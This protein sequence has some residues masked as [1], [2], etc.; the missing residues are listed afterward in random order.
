MAILEVPGVFQT[1]AAALAAAQP[2]DTINLGVGYGPESVAVIVSNITISGPASAI[3]INLNIAP[4]VI[5]VTLTGDAPINV[6]DSAGGDNV[7]TGNAG[8]NE[9][10]V[11]GGADTVDGGAGVDR[12]VVDYSAGAG[13]NIVTATSFSGNGNTINYSNFEHYTVLTGIAADTITLAGGDNYIDAGEGGNIITSGS[14]ANTVITGSAPDTITL[15]DG[16]NNVSSGAGSDILSIGNG[17]NT[18][19]AGD[20]INIVTVGPA[21]IGDNYIIA[22]DGADSITVGSGNNYVDAGGGINI[23]IV[24]T[25]GFGNNTVIAGDGADTMSIGMGNNFVDGGDGANIIAVGATGSGNNTILTGIGADTITTGSGDNFICAG[26]GAN[27][28]TAGSGNNFI[29]TGGAADT[30]AASGGNNVIE[31]GGGA[32][33]ITTTTGN[34]IIEVGDA[35]DVIATG[36]GNDIIKDLGGAGSIAAG[37]GH[38]RII[39]DFSA[40]IGPLSNTLTGAGPDYGGTFAATTFSGVEEFHITGGS[41][42]DSF[43]TGSGADVLEGGAGNDTLSSGGGS[44][45][46]YGGVGDT[47][48]GGEDVAGQDFDVLVLKDFGAYNIVYNIDPVTG[49]EDT[50]NGIVQQLDAP[51]GTVIGQIAFSNIERIEFVDTTVTTPED[52]PLTGNLFVPVITTTVTSFVVGNTN[53]AAGQTASRTEGD[54]TINADGSYTFT[55]AP[56]YNGPAPVINYTTLD[57]STVPAVIQTSSLIIEVLPV[58]DVC[59]IPPYVCFVQGSM[60]ATADG[61]IP[62]EDLKVGDLIQTFDHGL[63]P[64]RWIGHRHLSAVDLAKNENMR[65]IRIHK[66]VIGAEN[67]A[68]DLVV[69]PQHRILIA[70]KVV[71]RMFDK[72][73][74]LVAAKQ[75]LAI[76]GVDIA[77]D[78]EDVTYF[79]ILFDQHEIVFANGCPSESLYLG[80]EALN[81]LSADGRKE[82]YKLFPEVASPTFMATSCRPFIQNKKARELALCHKK[83]RK[84]F[85]DIRFRLQEKALHFELKSKNH[86]LCNAEYSFLNETAVHEQRYDMTPIRAATNFR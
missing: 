42:A 86:G 62:I 1:I 6:T 67:G 22:G 69:S 70:S 2:G 5:G 17:N 58:V 15:G 76:D 81:S 10:T 64:L 47:V 34:D 43:V 79:H 36:T 3:G 21:G 44:D 8:D 23:V 85:L 32:N 65:P 31:A 29:M 83:N 26:E 45:V 57:T 9:I 33:I 4:G 74:V 18:V 72:T 39:M 14:G 11:T 77:Y 75:L 68:G 49:L 20:G 82:I 16:D 55:P 53:Y 80:K 51:G 48:D 63:Q 84:S 56:N 52:T 66:D 24:G 54:L 19:D 30:I 12:L 61:E 37:A 50:E 59:V 38:D 28:V 73:E 71:Q 46:I 60:I 27:I 25:T 40:E 13:A 7:I 35:A 41:G 78:F